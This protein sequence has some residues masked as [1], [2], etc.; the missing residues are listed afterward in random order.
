MVS[1]DMYLCM[2]NH[3]WISNHGSTMDELRC[4]FTKLNPYSPGV[5]WPLM[6]QVTHFS[7]MSC[8]LAKGS[9]AIQ[10]YVESDIGHDIVPAARKGLRLTMVKAWLQQSKQLAG[11]T[12]VNHATI[13]DILLW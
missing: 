10:Q 8:L 5:W 6:A 11:S 4:Y 13:D 12:M 7:T 2:V 3:G 1:F 9:R